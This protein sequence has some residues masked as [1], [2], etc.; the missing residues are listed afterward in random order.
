M[1]NNGFS[2]SEEKKLN[3]GFCRKDSAWRAELNRN[4]N[5]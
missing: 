2:K 3:L 1:H 5:I 4:K